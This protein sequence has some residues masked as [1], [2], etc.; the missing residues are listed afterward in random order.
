M[1]TTQAL[2]ESSIGFLEI[3]ETGN[4]ESGDRI[5]RREETRNG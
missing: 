2:K 1:G 3:L 4:R 5:H